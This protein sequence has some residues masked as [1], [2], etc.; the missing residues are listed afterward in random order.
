[1]RALSRAEEA[2]RLAA[3]LSDD[4]NIEQHSP[5]LGRV[6]AGHVEAAWALS[7]ALVDLQNEEQRVSTR[8]LLLVLHLLR[9]FDFI[10]VLLGSWL[11][12]F[13]KRSCCT[14]R[15]RGIPV[16]RIV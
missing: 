10:F 5:G 11:V 2:H 16:T 12:L 9:T 4:P 13:T 8:D 7:A 1:M 15:R 3:A 14:E 6:L